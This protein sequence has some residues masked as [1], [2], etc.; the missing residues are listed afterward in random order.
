M[1]TAAAIAAAALLIVACRTWL[2][3]IFATAIDPFRADMLVVVR[4]GLRRI[5]QG[6]NPYVIYHVPWAAPLTYGPLLW[7]PYTIP[8]ALHADLR[9]LGV[10]GELFVPVAC[11]AAV[12]ASAWRGRMTV[13]AAALIMLGAIAFNGELK[14]FTAI[15]HTP[16]YWPLLA[17]FAWLV[18]R[19]RWQAAAVSLGLLVTARSTMVAM[20][21]VLMMAVWQRDRPRFGLTLLLV[22]LAAGVP[23]LPFAIWDPAALV[24]ALYGG[25]AKVIKEVVWPDATVP[26]T[27]GLTGVM[28]THHL[29]AW[30]ERVQLVILAAVFAGC[31][32]ALGRGRSPLA[33]MGAALLAF[34]MT[35]LWPVYYIYFDGLLLLAAGV[36]ADMPPFAAR[37]STSSVIRGWTAA[38][39]A[40]VLLVAAGA[41]AMLPAGEVTAT[42]VAWRDAPQVVGSVLIPRR[43][44]SGALID[45]E[46][47]PAPAGVTTLTATLNGVSL[48]TVALGREGEQITLAAPSALWQR[49]VNNLELA[50]AARMPIGPVRVRPPR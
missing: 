42:S 22:V 46:A 29:H 1:A 14:D 32:L 16:V 36:L 27:I 24:Y 2:H 48:G 25:Y 39:A 43:T 49:G 13:A 26:H 7:G 33:L 28:L 38:L 17:L 44:I 47:G 8:M 50:V 15:A 11:A 10:V 35:T 31:W 30:V 19:R 37:A 20:V 18:V 45:V 9:F 34:S 41:W 12:I 21:P 3:Q 5:G 23:F 4:E 40:A 6:L